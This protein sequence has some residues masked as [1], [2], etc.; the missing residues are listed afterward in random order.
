MEICRGKKPWKQLIENDELTDKNL[1]ISNG[2]HSPIGMPKGDSVVSQW[3]SS[4][5][6][7]P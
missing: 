5:I 2:T 7:A 6:S 4:R 1:S 3:W